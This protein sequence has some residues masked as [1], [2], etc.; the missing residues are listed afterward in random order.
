MAHVGDEL[1]FVL[2]RNR[3]LSSLL[4]DFT[5]QPRILHRE[6]RL[7]GKGLHEVDRTRRKISGLAALQYQS[8][9]NVVLSEE[10]HD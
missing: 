10:G 2:T 7:I 5:E 1:G 4:I 3:E 6:D 8:A 9:K